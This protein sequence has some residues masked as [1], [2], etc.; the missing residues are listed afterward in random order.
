MNWLIIAQLITAVVLTGLVLV[1][2][3][4]AG[5]SKSLGGLGGYHTKKG[6]EQVVFVL[7]FVVAT[8][9]VLLGIVNAFFS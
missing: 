8:L 1:Q 5:L 3:Q 7:T 9:F 6:V 2:N 4:E